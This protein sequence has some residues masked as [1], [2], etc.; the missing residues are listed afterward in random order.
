MAAILYGDDEPVLINGSVASCVL[1]LTGSYLLTSGA[2]VDLN[3][4]SMVGLAGRKL[5]CSSRSFNF[6]ALKSSSCC[7]LDLR[8]K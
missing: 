7:G 2:T 8:R 3:M 1:S 5:S 4:V 6:D